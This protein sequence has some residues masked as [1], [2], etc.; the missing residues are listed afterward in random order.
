MRWLENNFEVGDLVFLRLHSYRKYSLNMN[1][2]EKLKP[3]FYEPYRVITRFGEV[4]YKVELPQ[5]SI[6]HKTFHVSCLKNLLDQQ[7][8]SLKDIP[9]LDEEGQLFLAV[10]RNGREDAT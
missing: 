2:A 7:V 4:A 6:I 8:T 3:H 5:G 9:P 1:S 10:E